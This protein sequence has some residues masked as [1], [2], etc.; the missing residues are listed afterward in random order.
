MAAVALPS[1]LSQANNAKQVEAALHSLSVTWSLIPSQ[2]SKRMQASQ[3]RSISIWP[4]NARWFWGSFQSL[5]PPQNQRYERNNSYSVKIEIIP[6][7]NSLND[8]IVKIGRIDFTENAI[9]LG[10]K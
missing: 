5:E 8:L 3:I 7:N 2:R 4:G 1:L 10:K 9:G 6:P